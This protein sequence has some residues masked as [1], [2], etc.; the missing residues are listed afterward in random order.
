MTKRTATPGVATA[1][2]WGAF[3]VGTLFFAFSFVHR[4]APSVMTAELMRDF[5]VGATALGALSAWYFY[6][7]AA[8]QLPI[9]MLNDRFGPRNL[10]SLAVALCALSSVGFAVS[11]SLFAASFFRAGIGASVAFAFVGTLTIAADWFA[12]ARF[13]MLA[14]AVQTVGMFGAMLGQAPLR[15]AVEQFGWRTSMS[16][17]GIIALG[18][19]GLLFVVVP[20]RRRNQAEA[21]ENTHHLFSG[22][23][24]V[25]VNPQSWACAGI[26]FGMTATM[27][28]FAGL[29]AVPWLSGVFAYPV[30]R[31]AG[32]VSLLFL[33]WA[34]GAPLMGW[35]S[36]YSGR[37]KPILVAGSACNI[38]IFALLIF[39]GLRAPTA[40]SIL[41]FVLGFSGSMM[42]VAFGS[43]REVNSL[44]HRATAIG[45]M[46]MCVVGSGAVMQPLIGGLLDFGWDGQMIAG[47]RV[48]SAEV[49]A[50]AL[51]ALLA[52]SL[53]ALVCALLLRETKCR[54]EPRLA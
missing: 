35:L 51:S 12:A 20:G 42:T 18:L 36:D 30:A 8:L 10:M 9:G 7:Y 34:I 45:L 38:V 14:G 23:R 33:G 1:R 54:Q 41:F 28:A 25:L 40:M 47:A 11:E 31:A 46:N 6:T 4:V 27:L 53:L 17:M 44:R 32:V 37:R 26:G 29:W 2:A 13:A 49:Y 16:A 43:M 21:A 19:A 50:T 22:M 52:T 24:A 3:A 15:Y 5:S 48:Y 39:G